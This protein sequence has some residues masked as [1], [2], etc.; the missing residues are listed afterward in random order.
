MG[1]LKSLMINDDDDDDDG[2]DDDDAGCH[3]EALYTL[4][5]HL[6]YTIYTL[7]I[8]Y[9]YTVVSGVSVIFKNNSF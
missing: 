6:L 3:F 2:D 7:V 4:F 9:L 8:H 5:I 1:Q